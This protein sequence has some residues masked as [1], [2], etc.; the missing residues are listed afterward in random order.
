MHNLRQIKKYD[1]SGNCE[2]KTVFIKRVL[3]HILILIYKT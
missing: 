2:R 1:K 3:C